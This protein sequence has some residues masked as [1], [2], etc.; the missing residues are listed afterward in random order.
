MS[1]HQEEIERLH[2]EGEQLHRDLDLLRE[3]RGDILLAIDADPNDRARKNQLQ[4]VDTDIARRTQRLADTQDKATAA[5]RADL[6]AVERARVEGIDAAC[7]VCLTHAQAAKARAPQ[8]DKAID[9]MLE[10]FVDQEKDL[11]AA[12]SAGCDLD[13]RPDDLRYLLDMAPI[14]V[15]LA[16]RLARGGWTKL[17]FMDISHPR[18]PTT[19]AQMTDRRHQGLLTRIARVR[20]A[21]TAKESAA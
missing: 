15:A 11:N 20:A 12:F 9:E 17:P 21:T 3:T 18:D 14:G 8:I 5:E 19:V 1:K 13:I 16:D 6:S 10:L 4:Q 2:R 7:K